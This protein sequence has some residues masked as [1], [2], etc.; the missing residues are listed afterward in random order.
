MMGFSEE[1]IPELI[2]GNRRKLAKEGM[3]LVAL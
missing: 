2:L 3:E 1:L